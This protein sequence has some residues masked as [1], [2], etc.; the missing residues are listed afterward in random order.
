M[1][2]ASGVLAD[3]AARVLAMAQTRRQLAEDLPSS[4]PANRLPSA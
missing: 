4:Y 2:A 1:L 3:V